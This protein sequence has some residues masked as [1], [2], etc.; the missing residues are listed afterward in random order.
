MEPAELKK[1][2]GKDLTF[3]GG[4]IDTQKVLP[5]GTVQQVKDEVR[6][7]IDDFAP[8]GG[9]VFNTVHNI[10]A[11]VSPENLMAMWEALHEYGEY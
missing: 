1:D 6:K 5:N 2:F 11:D 7:R 8:G 10:Q 4:G 3:W 9:F